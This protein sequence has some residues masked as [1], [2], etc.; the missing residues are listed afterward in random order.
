MLHSYPRHVQ[1]VELT[2]K[3]AIVLDGKL[4]EE[5]WS[6]VPWLSGDFVDI[7]RHTDN[8]LNAVPSNFQTK[9]K[10]RWDR[11]FLYVGA[12]LTEPFVY[13]NLT[14]HNI[15]APYHDNDFEVFIDTTGTGEYYKEFEMN[16]LNATYDVNWGVA[17]EAGLNCTQGDASLWYVLP[18][19]TNTSFGG[20]FGNWTMRNS[21]FPGLAGGGLTS[22]TSYELNTFGTFVWPSSKWQL[23]IAF[24]IHSGV[25]HGGLLDADPVV[26]KQFDLQDPGLISGSEIRYWWI[27]FARA[28]HPR[29]YQLKETSRSTVCPFNCTPELMYAA[30]SLINQDSKKCA[31]TKTYWPTLLGIYAYSC[32]WEWVYQD[33]GSE[34]YMHRPASWAMLQF[35]KN[36]KQADCKNIEHPGRYI[37]KQ[38]H[39]AMRQYSTQHDGRFTETVQDLADNSYCS[40]SLNNCDLEALKFALMTSNIFEIKVQVQLHAV[41]LNRS[42]T[43]RPCYQAT[44]AVIPPITKRIQYIVSI[45]ENRLTTV[46][47]FFTPNVG[48]PSCL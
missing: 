14:G 13:G 46:K 10:L 17:D 12:E 30:P 35:S 11:K 45:N 26:Q 22:A 47:H 24:P 1:A 28:E 42:C 38:I 16:V 4:D 41:K 34:A 19:C 18:T 8:L 40:Y 5:A 20:Y 9:V 43:S 27:D 7:T 25:N 32:Y 44:V 21:V 31:E 3:E 33:L 6:A 29:T 36:T 37:A 39:L 2:G 15:H 48:S 23:E